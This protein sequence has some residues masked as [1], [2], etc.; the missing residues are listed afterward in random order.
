MCADPMVISEMDCLALC[1]AMIDSYLVNIQDV[2][3]LLH[4][5]VIEQRNHIQ[6][7]FTVAYTHVNYSKFP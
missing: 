4:Y 2:V 6:G 3:L 1:S 5:L 7:H